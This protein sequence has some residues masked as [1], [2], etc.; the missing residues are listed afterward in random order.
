[1]FLIRPRLIPTIFLRLT[2]FF[3]FIFVARSLLDPQDLFHVIFVDRVYKSL[4]GAHCLVPWEGSAGAGP[5]ELRS[6]PLY[7]RRDQYM[8]V[9][10]TTAVL[11]NRKT[12]TECVYCPPRLA[13]VFAAEISSAQGMSSASKSDFQSSSAE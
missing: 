9:I 13:V 5:N 7:I 11:Q 6:Q 12:Q 10:S 8:L 4:V 3:D 2:K 1:M